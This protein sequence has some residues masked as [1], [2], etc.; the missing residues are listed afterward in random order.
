MSPE[1]PVWLLAAWVESTF[2]SPS[3]MVRGT[4][5]PVWLPTGV[6]SLKTPL[7]TKLLAPRWASCYPELE[8]REL[9]AVPGGMRGEC[10]TFL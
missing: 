8:S 10:L 6:P 9:G 2:L 4:Q 1:S 5:Y 7:R 3:L